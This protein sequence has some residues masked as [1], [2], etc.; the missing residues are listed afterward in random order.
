MILNAHEISEFSGIAEW[1]NSKQRS[2]KSTNSG[3]E[4]RKFTVEQMKVIH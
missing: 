2:A 4:Y 1:R 3:D